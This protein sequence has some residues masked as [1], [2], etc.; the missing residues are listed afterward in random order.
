LLRQLSFALEQLLELLLVQRCE[1]LEEASAIVQPLPHGLF[2]SPRDVQQGPLPVVPDGQIQG[3]VQVALLAATGGFAAGASPLD[4]GTA[5]ERLLGD[6]L[7]ES[8]T[9]VAFWGRALRSLAHG[10]SSPA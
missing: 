9:G 7:G 10:V 3:P 1:L 8:G 4:E 2:Q 6:Q 5:Q